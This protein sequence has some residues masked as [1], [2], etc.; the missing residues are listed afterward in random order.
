MRKRRG[1]HANRA[2]DDYIPASGMVHSVEFGPGLVAGG[3]Q[4]RQLR[5]VVALGAG[6]PT[7]SFSTQVLP[8]GEQAVAPM[9]SL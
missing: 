4:A 8:H 1:P 7:Y 9:V 6:V 5:F 3:V 2:V